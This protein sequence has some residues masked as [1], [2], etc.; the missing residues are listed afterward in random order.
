MLDKLSKK[1]LKHLNE[2]PNPSDAYYNFDEDLD[3]IA[4]AVASD[5]ESV[6]SAVW[7]LQEQGYIKIS[8]Y[9][10]S[11]AAAGFYLDHK[12]IHHEE[13]NC[14]KAKERWKERFYGFVSGIL[15]SV[16]ASLIISWLS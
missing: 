6:R 15:V 3:K 10:G 1:I 8:Y 9:S 4:D 12:G 5:G 13:F 7:Y 11:E 2:Q 14:L 16:L